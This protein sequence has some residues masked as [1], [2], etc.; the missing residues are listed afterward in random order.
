[1]GPDS[2]PAIDNATAE[3]YNE[4]QGTKE[5]A[6]SDRGLAGEEQES[7]KNGMFRKL[8]ALLLA[9][10]MM[11]MAGAALAEVR[12]LDLDMTVPGYP[13][14]KDGWISESEY[15]DES[16][17]V[18]VFSK[19]RKPK[20]SKT[21]TVCRWVTI[22]IADPSQ[23]RT[24]MSNEN[25]DDPAYVPATYM[26]RDVNAIVALNGDFFKYNYSLG[27]V[28]RQGVLYRDALDGTWDAL[29]I[30]DHG[31]FHDVLAAT[32]ESMAATLSE[33][34]AQGRKAVNTFTFGPVLIKDGVIRDPMPEQ[35]YSYLAAQRIALLQLGEL[36]YAVVEIDADGGNGTGMNLDELARFILE[37]FPD[38]KMAYNL[39]GG[40]STHLIINGKAVHRTPSSRAVSDIIYFASAQVPEE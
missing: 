24:T 28:L 10:G 22:S 12:P 16:I 2:L 26:A 32:S 40:G 8:A 19:S 6:R 38:C 5:Q 15:Q 35:H 11:W 31:D 3:A 36:E 14:R 25:Y 4:E 13:A 30:D 18:Q 17:H 9:C 37:I 33:L 23:L 29:V 27:Y 34:E 39:D 1:M 7:M 20:S 21:S